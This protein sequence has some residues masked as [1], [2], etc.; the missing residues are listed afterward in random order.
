MDIIDKILEEH[1]VILDKEGT[2]RKTYKV[3]EDIEIGIHQTKDEIYM[4]AYSYESDRNLSIKSNFKKLWNGFKAIAQH[5][6]ISVDKNYSYTFKLKQEEIPT[7][8]PITSDSENQ[9]ELLRKRIEK[10]I[11][12]NLQLKEENEELKYQLG[13]CSQIINEHKK[14]GRKNKFSNEQISEIKKLRNE[15]MSIRAI[16]KKFDCSVGLIHKLIKTR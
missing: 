15:N 13:E 7:P 2:I 12:E 4:Y 1:S 14:L 11:N 10:L 6:Y 16:A 8:T 9:L 5:N 3:N